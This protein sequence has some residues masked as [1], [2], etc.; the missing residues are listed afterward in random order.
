MKGK[1]IIIETDADETYPSRCQCSIEV[2][3]GSRYTYISIDDLKESVILLSI[4]CAEKVHEAL[5]RAIA[6]AIEQ[7]KTQ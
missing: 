6:F 5:G 4:S 3:G 1:T 2:T 7:R